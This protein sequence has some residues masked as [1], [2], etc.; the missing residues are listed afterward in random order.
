[1]NY[2]ED[3]ELDHS[4]LCMH[5]YM[6]RLDQNDQ[7][8]IC[9]TH[10][11]NALSNGYDCGGRDNDF[12]VNV[13]QSPKGGWIRYTCSATQLPWTPACPP[14]W[15]PRSCQ[16]ESRRVLPDMSNFTTLSFDTVWA[17]LFT[18]FIVTTLEDWQAVC[19]QTQQ[20]GCLLNSGRA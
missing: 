3:P 5:E 7:A 11:L 6:Y 9:Q 13:K 19:F 17:S 18:L 4:T 2:Y 12:C 15:M 8:E 20:V 1:M 14:L 16:C 10:V